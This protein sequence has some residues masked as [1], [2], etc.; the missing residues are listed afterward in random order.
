MLGAVDDARVRPVSDMPRLSESFN[1]VLL[2]S[3]GPG[4]VAGCVSAAVG[5]YEA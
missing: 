1:E 5:E 4:G 3:R 2:R